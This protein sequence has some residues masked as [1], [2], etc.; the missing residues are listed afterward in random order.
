LRAAATALGAGLLAIILVGMVRQYA[1]RGPLLD[2]ASERS[3]HVGSVPRGGGLGLVV[4]FVAAWFYLAWPTDPELLLVLVGL[5]VVGLAGWIDDHGGLSVRVRL[6]A[7]LLAG[8]SVLPLVLA[9]DALPAWLGPLGALVC[10]FW[11]VSAVNV[12]NF[13]DGIDGIIGIQ[14]AVFGAT[15]LLLGDRGGSAAQFGMILLA[16]SAGFLC[17]NLPKA[18]IFLGDVGSGTLG[19]LF[20][21][22]GGLLLLEGRVSFVQAWLPLYP[23]FLDAAVTLSRRIRRGAKVTEAHREHFYQ[24]LARESSHLVVA[25]G[26][27][28]ASLV[29]VAAVAVGAPVAAAVYLVGVAIVGFSWDRRIA[30]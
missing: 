19:L 10:V 27:G 26:Y 3:S 23:I 30:A 24:R 22:G 14:A 25:V 21:V 29:G 2:H 16:T 12:V 11:T 6:L 5:V 1:L 17:W 7:H 28:V 20:V 13:A 18:R 4:A 8:L 9:T 15:C